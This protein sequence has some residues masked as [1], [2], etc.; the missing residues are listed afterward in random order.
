MTDGYK[1]YRK[2]KNRMRCWPHLERKG[3]ALEESSDKEHLLLVNLLLRRL[4]A[5]EIGSISFENCPKKR[6]GV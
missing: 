2:Y 1:V 4:H 6:E 3:K 5:S